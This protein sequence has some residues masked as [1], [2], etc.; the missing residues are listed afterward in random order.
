LYEIPETTVGELA[1]ELIG[2]FN[3]TGARIVG[4]H[5]TKVRKVFLCEHINGGGLGDFFSDCNAIKEVEEEGYD[6]MIPLEI[7]DWT[8]SEYVRD[9][10]QLGKT[11]AIIE[12][13]HFNV[14]ELGMKYMEKWLPQV[15]GEALTIQ[16][17]QSGDCFSYITVNQEIR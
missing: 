14:E 17:I 13:G 9:A 11:K 4:N 1:K 2:K 3:L 12:M 16:Y 7:I 8:L 5:D 10:V 15:V 6:V